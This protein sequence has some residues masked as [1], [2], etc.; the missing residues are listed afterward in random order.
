MLEDDEPPAG[1]FLPSSGTSGPTHK[2]DVNPYHARIPLSLIPTALQ[3]LDLQP[4]DE[5]ILSV[6]RNAA[7]GWETSQTSNRTPQKGDDEQFVSKKDWRAVC[8]A[9]LDDGQRE[10]GDE[11]NDVDVDMAEAKENDG[12]DDDSPLSGDEYQESESDLTEPDED[13]DEEYYESGFVTKTSTPTEKRKAAGS[14][15][16][17]RTRSRKKSRATSLRMSDSD[18]GDVDMRSA[19]KPLTPR[20]KAECRRTFALF[21]P[22]IP[23]TELDR[24]KIMIKDITRVAKLLKQKVTAEDVRLPSLQSHCLLI[25]LY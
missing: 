5:D 23:D 7:S 21:F 2:A 25:L 20:Q 22:D 1:G 14:S 13:S 10:S 11:E 8:A 16:P 3:L 9:L 6:F 24:Q 17:R 12:V 15:L 19:P 4:D 18:E